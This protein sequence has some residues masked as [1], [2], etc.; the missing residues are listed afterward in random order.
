[1]IEF[2]TTNGAYWKSQWSL[3]EWEK[4]LKSWPNVY[5]WPGMAPSPLIGDPLWTIPSVHVVSWRYL[6]DPVEVEPED[7]E[8]QS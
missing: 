2:Y 3:Q 1:M 7:D 6:E 8:G 5:G 4:A